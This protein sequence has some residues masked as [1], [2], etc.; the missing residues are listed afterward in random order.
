MIVQPR[1]RL[2]FVLVIFAGVYRSFA[3]GLTF[4]TNILNVGYYSPNCV[5]AADVN[6][7]G[8]L[9]LISA[10]ADLPGSLSV[11]TNNGTGGFGFSYAITNVGDQPVYVVAADVNG[12]GKVD[13]IT[14]NIDADFR[15]RSQ[16]AATAFVSTPLC[17]RGQN[18]VTGVQNSQA[19]PRL[20]EASQACPRV[21]GREGGGSLG[22][23]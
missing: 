3:Q 6:G 17:L 11:L 21:P 5:C 12:D 13:L 20:P 14:A 10:N 8:R 7:D 19:V 4:T 15:R 1:L 23:V 2:L 18:P 9:D 16:T 22:T